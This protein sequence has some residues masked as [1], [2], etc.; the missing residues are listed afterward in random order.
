MKCAIG[1]PLFRLKWKGALL[2]CFEKVDDKSARCALREL[3]NVKVKWHRKGIGGGALTS[4]FGSASKSSKDTVDAVLVW[5][6]D[7]KKG[8]LLQ[9]QA[10]GADGKKVSRNSPKQTAGD[11]SK[12]VALSKIDKVKV[13][14]GAVIL[15]TDKGGDLL[16]IE[17]V[18]KDSTAIKDCFVLLVEW[19]GRRLM[20]QRRP[21]IPEQDR[22]MGDA[23]MSRG[24][25][26]RGVDKTA[27]PTK[28]AREKIVA[29]KEV[30]LP[31]VKDEAGG[32]TYVQKSSPVNKGRRRPVS[33]P[34]AITAS[35][36]AYIQLV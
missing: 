34:N 29:A 17:I 30:K 6:D 7:R 4:W 5:V 33:S 21:A 8:P 2:P 13:Q 35:S 1:G 26:K 27:Q 28:R 23:S 22:E 16:C 36:S 20:G 3:N 31:V 14:E 11:T 25:T 15:Q 12:A 32:K 24:P 9:V 18:S 19:D 10:L